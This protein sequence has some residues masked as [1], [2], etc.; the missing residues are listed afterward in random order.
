MAGSSFLKLSDGTNL[1]YKD[2]GT[3]VPVVFSH[4]WPLSSDAFEDQ[5]IFLALKGY[6]VIAHDRRG[7]GRSSQPWEGNNMD[8]YADDLAELVKHLGL[9]NAIHIGHST[10]GG[11]V[12][13]YIGRHGTTNVL[14]AILIGAIPPGML[15]SRTNPDGSPIEVFDDLRNNVLK[16]R[17]QFFRNFGPVFY[18]FNH[19]ES[20][21]SQGVIDSFWL[22]GMQASIKSLYDCVQ[23]LSETDQVEDLK[24]MDIP[25]LVLYGDDDQVVPPIASSKRAVK[26]LPKPTE[27]V[28]PGASHGLCT[29]HKDKVNED[30]L[31]FIT[32]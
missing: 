27:I 16:D 19:D 13:R 4:G 11:E 31:R 30:L 3:G 10:G 24:K 9:K 17:S 15:K 23:A 28:Y 12:A 1:F 7:H 20:K 5:M 22:Q 14:K 21:K 26:L 6:R 29:T 18:G 32:S 2:W 25:T 8:Q